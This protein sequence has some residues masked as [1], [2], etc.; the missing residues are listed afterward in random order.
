MY[1]KNANL[2]KLIYNQTNFAF[3]CIF[4]RKHIQNGLFGEQL[5]PKYK[6]HSLTQS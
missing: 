6:N 3:F 1:F 2:S 5:L 4:L